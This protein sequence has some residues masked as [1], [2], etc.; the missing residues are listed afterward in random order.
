MNLVY[1]DGYTLNPGD[2][3]WEALQTLG[4]L[5]IYD[6]TDASEVVSRSREAEIILT[7]K[8][9]ITRSMMAELPRLKHIAVTATGYNIIDLE[10]A[11]EHGII[12]THVKA[13]SSYSVAQHTFALL[14]ALTNRVETHDRAVQNGKWEKCEDFTF[15]ETPL[16]ELY[17]KTLGLIGLGDIGEKVAEIG[18]A[19][20]MNVI[21]YR[22]NTEK[23]PPENVKY[24]SIEEVFSQSDVLSLHCPLTA[25]TKEIV[26]KKHLVL[27]KS[28]AF[29]INTGRG[30]LIQ[31]DDLAQALRDKKIAGAGLD[32]LSSEPPSEDN[33]LLH[34]DNCVITPHIAWSLDGARKR[35]MGM[36]VDNIKAYQ[37]GKPINVVSG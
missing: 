37:D 33:P 11:K 1:L 16:V 21:A 27:M 12:V 20:G 19:L 35:L 13:Y 18:S 34:I 10:A 25:E 9:P 2:L 24:A 8:V 30:D 26:N 5:K 14:F 4:N 6:R 23:Q 7:N 31:E 36:I 32:V 3:S 29:L 28:E 17:G 15:R 22:K